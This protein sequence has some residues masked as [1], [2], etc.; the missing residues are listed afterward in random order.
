MDAILDFPK[1]MLTRRL[2]TIAARMDELCSA[3]RA[4]V[5]C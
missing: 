2:G 1:S 5:D 3:V 4:T